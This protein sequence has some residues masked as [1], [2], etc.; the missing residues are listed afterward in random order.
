L[1][2][3]TLLQIIHMLGAIQVGLKVEQ[4]LNFN[5]NFVLDQDLNLQ[6]MGLRKMF[7]LLG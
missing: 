1:G 4:G 2:S 5:F 3:Y 6:V 7:L